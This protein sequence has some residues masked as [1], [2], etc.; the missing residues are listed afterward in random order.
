MKIKKENNFFYKE[1]PWEEL[2]EELLEDEFSIGQCYEDIPARKL[3]CKKC[4]STK[5]IV[6]TGNYYTAIKCPKCKWER[7]IHDG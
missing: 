2:T 7:C 5:F 4:G 6:G 3:R 1:I